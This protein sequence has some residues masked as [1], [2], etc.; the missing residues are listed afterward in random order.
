VGVLL[1]L[2]LG[3]S[4]LRL[5]LSPSVPL[6]LYLLRRVP[7]PLE[8]G[9]LVVF[10][11]PPSVQLWWSR[12]LP[13]LKPIAGLPGDTVCVWAQTFLVNG[14]SFG[15]VLTE[16]SDGRPVPRLDGCFT[17]APDAVIVASDTPRSLDSRYFGAVPIAQ[18]EGV[19]TPL[20]TWRWR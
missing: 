6:G 2:V 1:L 17:V 19:A 16:S 9:M 10:P 12:W 7:A 4:W 20:L 14:R 18:L 5:N 13:L 3:L 11:V 15:P 8:R